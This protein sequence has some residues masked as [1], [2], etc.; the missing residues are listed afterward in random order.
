MSYRVVRDNYVAE[1]RT[2]PEEMRTPAAL[3]ESRAAID[4]HGNCSVVIDAIVQPGDSTSCRI[5]LPDGAELLYAAVDDRPAKNLELVD[6]AWTAPNGPRFLPRIYTLG[7]RQRLGS[8]GPWKLAPVRVMV[9]GRPVAAGSRRWQISMDDRAPAPS[10][11]RGREIT[12][13]D[14]SQSGYQKLAAMATAA[15]PLVFQLPEW[16][17]RSWFQPWLDRLPME[18]DGEAPWARFRTLIDDSVNRFSVDVSHARWYETA[19]NGDLV[20]RAPTT[21]SAVMRWLLA[22]AIA[23]SAGAVYRYRSLLAPV[24]A[25]LARIPQAGA[26]AAGVAWWLLLSPAFVG[27]VIA[28]VAL[29]S[30]VRAFQRASGDDASAVVYLAPTAR[31]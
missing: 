8:A 27:L 11:L 26:V 14:F 19:A 10:V 30:A 23:V 9:R 5:A 3:I 13:S 6:G 24:G 29:A 2:F 15:T 20:L 1:Q 25:A 16:E 17:A 21:E 22:L 4:A 28:G 12:F 7:Y 31:R 18:F